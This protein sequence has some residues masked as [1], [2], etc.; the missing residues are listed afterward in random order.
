[1]TTPKFQITKRNL[2]RRAWACASVHLN[3]GNPMPNG[4]SFID[5]WAGFFD[6]RRQERPIATVKV[7]TIGTNY[8][9]TRRQVKVA[10]KAGFDTLLH[11]DP[12]NQLSPGEAVP[13][14]QEYFGSAGEDEI[15]RW[16]QYGNEPDLT[17]DGYTPDTW[18]E[19]YA[20]VMERNKQPCEVA[21]GSWASMGQAL[22]WPRPTL[23]ALRAR[24]I[25]PTLHHAHEYGIRPSLYLR[26]FDVAAALQ[27]GVTP[28]VRFANT[29][30]D[31]DFTT[32]DRYNYKGATWAVLSNLE[33]AMAGVA[34][35]DFVLQNSSPGATSGNGMF[36][37][38]E[39]PMESGEAMR[40]IVAPFTRFPMLDVRQRHPWNSLS[41]FANS[42]GQVIICNYPVEDAEL[43]IQKWFN[44]S[45]RGFY[46]SVGVTTQ[47]IEDYVTGAGPIPQDT[48]GT[49]DWPAMKAS[50]E[51]VVED[52]GATQTCYVRL[53]FAASTCLELGSVYDTDA[54]TAQVSG[55]GREIRATMP[56][57]TTLW[58]QCG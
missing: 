18:A 51:Q 53:P 1:M 23:D 21:F 2:G 49:I 14:F 7:G 50:Y 57:Y 37:D 32:N 9:G 15:P 41:V 36:Q 52:D 28:G 29:E 10:N 26:E 3:S 13:Y 19:L 25:D 6:L 34:H 5:T 48:L 20:A 47:D 12:G 22:E 8:G 16:V 17:P 24:G 45:K 42:A 54:P 35:C 4:A 43:H 56:P 33:H 38:D 44:L 27:R 58:L 30:T 55:S 31:L 46:G 40:D 11:I 39:T